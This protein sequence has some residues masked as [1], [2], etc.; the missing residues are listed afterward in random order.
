MT[1]VAAGEEKIK[2]F[3]IPEPYSFILYKVSALKIRCYQLR[4]IRQAT[5]MPWKVEMEIKAVHTYGLKVIRHPAGTI[6]SHGE[7]ENN[8]ADVLWD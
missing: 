2:Y 3:L 6:C 5:K 7:V 4:Q 8:K 1:Y